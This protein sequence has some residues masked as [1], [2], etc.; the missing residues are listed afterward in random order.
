MRKQSRPNGARTLQT[1]DWAGLPL[2]ISSDLKNRCDPSRVGWLFWTA[3]TAWAGAQRQ[4][5]V[6]SEAQ[7]CCFKLQVI[8]FTQ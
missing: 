6:W 1:P 7:L 8:C 4:E 3:G 2:G 5:Q